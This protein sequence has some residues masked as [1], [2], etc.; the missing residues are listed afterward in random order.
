MHGRSFALMNDAGD[1]RGRYIGKSPMQA[2]SKAFTEM[3]HKNQ[4]DNFEDFQQFTIREITRGSKHK[5]YNYSG[6]Y[7]KYGMEQ[8]IELGK[9]RTLCFFGKNYIKKLK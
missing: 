1:Y 9:N 7:I 8:K 3:R 4:G 2:A 5:I 6:K